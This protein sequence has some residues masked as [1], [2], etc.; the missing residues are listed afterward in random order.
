MQRVEDAC[1]HRWELNCYLD[2]ECVN[3]NVLEW[4]AYAQW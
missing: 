1:V 3:A 2:K 4:N